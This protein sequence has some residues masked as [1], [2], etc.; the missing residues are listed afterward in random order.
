LLTCLHRSRAPVSLRL[1]LRLQLYQL[2]SDRFPFWDVDLHRMDELGGAAI[3]DGILHGPVI[4]QAHPW[5]TSVHASAQDLI[6]RMLDRNVARRITA[7]EALQHPWF[8]HALQSSGAG[9]RTSSPSG[10]AVV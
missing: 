5:N 3:R 10:M 8:A 6:L 1:A 4:F 9:A 2:L 7:A